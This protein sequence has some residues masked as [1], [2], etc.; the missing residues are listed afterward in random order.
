MKLI[1]YLLCLG[2]LGINAA[3]AQQQVDL[4]AKSDQGSFLIEINWTPN[5]FGKDNIFEITFIEPE[6]GI[7][8]EDIKYGFAVKDLESGQQ[9]TRRVDQVS[10]EQRVRFDRAGPYTLEIQDIEGLGENAEL[11]V[12]VTPEFPPVFTIAIM[13]AVMV[14]V[15]MIRLNGKNLF[16][17]SD[18]KW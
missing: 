16:S 18:K 3:Y 14:A 7:K 17:R 4:R 1:F 12:P 8:L 6:T 5:D 10:N 13:A 15:T 9:I 2:I 11:Q